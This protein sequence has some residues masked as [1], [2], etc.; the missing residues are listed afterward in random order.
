MKHSEAVH[1]R[2]HL[3]G[4]ALI[5]L[6]FLCV[7]IMNTLGKI[8]IQTVPIGVLLFA[9]NLIPLLLIAPFIPQKKFK[10]IRTSRLLL[11][12]L[13]AMTGLLSY[14]CLFIAVKYISLVEA[15]LLANSAPL[16]LPLIAIVW[17]REKIPLS[18]WASLLIGFIGVFF[19]LNP[20]GNILQNSMAL[21]ALL[22]SLFSAIALQSVRNL[23]STESLLGIVFFYFLFASIT[24][25]PW[26]L[27][28]WNGLKPEDW[29]LLISIGILLGATQLLL[30]KAYQYASPLLLGPFNYS[31]IVFAGLIQWLIW[32]NIPNIMG[33]I[34]II[35]VSAGGILTII[36]QKK[37]KDLKNREN[38]PILE[39][40]SV[41]PDFCPF[42]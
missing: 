1:F 2:Q 5:L 19:I 41:Y 35:L 36:Q 38:I 23:A 34:G 3:L 40:F 33:F 22:G 42:W 12:L 13:R 27:L 15:T 14:G 24:T 11:H 20:S 18:V 32:H 26:M 6:A 10:A 25:L 9:Q 31:V 37:I 30:A 28:Q 4:I 7:A 39:S 8:A 29:I 17:M 21:V 16:F